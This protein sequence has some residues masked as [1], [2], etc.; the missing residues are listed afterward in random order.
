M[1]VMTTKGL[2]DHDQLS[3]K[4]VVEWGDNHRKVASEFYLGKE[5]VRRDVAVSA[6]RPIEAVAQEGVLG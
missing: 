3:I 6:L 5:L 1:K 2:I 4:D